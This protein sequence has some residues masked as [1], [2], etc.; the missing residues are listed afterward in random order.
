MIFRHSYSDPFRRE[1]PATR[2]GIDQVL[3]GNQAQIQA[4]Q[5]SYMAQV[6]RNNQQVAQW[7][8]QRALQQGQVQQDLQRQ[9]TAQAIG[10]QRAA[11]ASQGGDINS[12][13][14]VDLVGDTARSGEFSAQTIGNDA[15]ARA[16]KYLLDANTAAGQASLYDT[17]A[18]NVWSTYRNNLLADGIKSGASLL[19]K[20]V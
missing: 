11:L 1:R 6:A 19:G 15:Q 8:A 7:N 5:A 12:G 4:N 17:Q 13:S 3:A 10:Q 18:S 9:K 14:S 2:H 20:Y 16:Y